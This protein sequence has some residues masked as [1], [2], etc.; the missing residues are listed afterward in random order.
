VHDGRLVKTLTST[1]KTGV[2]VSHVD[3]T[4][5]G[6]YVVAVLSCHVTPDHVTVFDI[7]TAKVTFDDCTE[8]NVIQIMT[9]DDSDKVRQNFL[10]IVC[11]S[12]Q[13]T[14]DEMC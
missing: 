14:A 8:S 13:T 2:V 11:V 12:I 6:L 10:H 4:R 3:V 1:L 7:S 5:N 9:T